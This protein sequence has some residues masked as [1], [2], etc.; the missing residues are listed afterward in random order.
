MFRKILLKTLLVI[1]KQIFWSVPLLIFLSLSFCLPLKHIMHCRVSWHVVSFF[2]FLTAQRIIWRFESPCVLSSFRKKI[3]TKKEVI[4]MVSALC[5]KEIFTVY[6][7]SNDWLFFLFSFPVKFSF[8][9]F[10]ILAYYPCHYTNS[11]LFLH[12]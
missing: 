5:L 9:E 10:L 12:F 11:L 8:T 1:W 2:F 3:C 6:V 4:L 7:I